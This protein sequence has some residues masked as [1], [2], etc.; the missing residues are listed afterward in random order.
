MT[1]NQNLPFSCIHRG[2]GHFW[3]LG[4]VLVIFRGLLYHFV[5]AEQAR[6]KQMLLGRSLEAH[7]LDRAGF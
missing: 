3:I 5:R 1:A 7:M 4:M 6:A 2:K